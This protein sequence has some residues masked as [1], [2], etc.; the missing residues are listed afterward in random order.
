M[1]L[2]FVSRYWD[3]ANDT[4][5]NSE[6]GGYLYING[7][8]YDADEELYGRF[9]DICSE[10]AIREVIDDVESDGIT[11]WAPIHTEPDYD[12]VFELETNTRLNP[13]QFFE[14][15]LQEIDALLAGAITATLQPLLRQL[16]YSSLI[17]ALEAYLA[18]TLSFWVNADKEVFKCFVTSCEEFK[19]RK[20]S[21]AE[22]FERMN[23]LTKEVEA[24]LQQLVWHRLDKVGPLM[25]DALGIEVSEI[26]PLMKHI[27]VR[28]DIVHRGGKT[29]EGK[30][31]D[32]GTEDVNALRESVTV[33]VSGIQSKLQE[34]F[35]QDFSGLTGDEEF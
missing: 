34:R 14:R 23:D 17:A 3:P 28:H 8:P 10:E 16:L 18:D 5:Y 9:A 20:F 24:Y 33:F 30:T 2:W 4:P 13:S 11:E 35:P 27:M 7:G 6:E 25:S 32:I 26:G 12:Q 31:I 15:R 19:Q 22:I 1:R 29:K 21:L